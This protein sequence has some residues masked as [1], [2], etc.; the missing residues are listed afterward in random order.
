MYSAPNAPVSECVPSGAKHQDDD[1]LYGPPL[2]VIIKEAN[3]VKRTHGWDGVNVGILDAGVCITWSS[4]SLVNETRNEYIEFDGPGFSVACARKAMGA[5][6]W[7]PVSH[8][9]SVADDMSECDCLRWDATTRKWVGKKG[10]GAKRYMTAFP[11]ADPVDCLYKIDD[12]PPSQ[13]ALVRRMRARLS[14]MSGM[15]GML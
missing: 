10:A 4:I 2:T 8:I 3:K 5:A 13:M 7:D 15:S 6:G 1:Y 9:I 14:G 11:G 12:V